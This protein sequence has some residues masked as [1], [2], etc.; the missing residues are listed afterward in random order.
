MKL[1]IDRVAEDA[2][3]EPWTPLLPGL[4]LTNTEAWAQSANRQVDSKPTGQR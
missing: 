4:P 2:L 3:H 1:V